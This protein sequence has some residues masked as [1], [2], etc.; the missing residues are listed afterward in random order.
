MIEKIEGLSNLRLDNFQI[1]HNFI[2]RNGLDDVKHLLECKPFGIVDLTGNYIKEAEEL[3]KVFS[4][5]G[6]VII[7]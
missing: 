3:D 5:M 6:F 1:Q 7:T 2:G 4:K